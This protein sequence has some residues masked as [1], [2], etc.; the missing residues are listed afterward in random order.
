[1]ATNK[2]RQA[3]HAVG[4]LQSKY[5]DLHE[6]K[7]HSCINIDQSVPEMKEVPEEGDEGVR[8]AKQQ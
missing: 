8:E 4:E 6:F 3:L 1:M 2:M 7:K 5:V